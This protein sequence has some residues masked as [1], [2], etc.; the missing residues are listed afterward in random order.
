MPVHAGDTA[1]SVL[2]S[3]THEVTSEKKILIE[4]ALA[5]NRTS[6]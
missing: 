5:M 6:P 3:Q 1:L 4:A 2:Q